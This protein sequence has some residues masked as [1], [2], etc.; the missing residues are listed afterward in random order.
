MRGIPLVVLVAF[1]VVTGFLAGVV[2]TGR[3]LTSHYEDGFARIESCRLERDQRTLTCATP[4]GAGDVLLGTD[5]SEETSRVVITVHASVFVP[6][7]DTFKNLS[8][9]LDS[10]RI[11]LV[12]PLGDRQIVDGASGKIVRLL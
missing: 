12:E 11:V 4:V 7:P 10:T 9:T 2:V 8:A 6:G 1:A 3:T 5:V